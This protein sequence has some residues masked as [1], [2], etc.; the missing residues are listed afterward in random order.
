MSRTWRRSLVAG[1]ATALAAAC[2][3]GARAQPA[4]PA[5]TEGPPPLPAMVQWHNMP[6]GLQYAEVKVGNGAS[7][8]DGQVAVVHFTGWLDDGT[9]FD[10]SRDHKKPFGFPLG[11]GQVIKGWDEGVRGMRIGGT[12]RLIVPPALGYASAGVPG[13]VPPDATLIFD[14]EL[15][16]I[17]DK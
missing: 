5:K 13:L 17:V 9:Q 16:H 15:L 8:H 2:A 10:S 14:I 6:S 12:R 1:V 4:T 3:A 11:S 7:P